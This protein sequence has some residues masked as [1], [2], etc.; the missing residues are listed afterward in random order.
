MPYPRIAWGIILSDFR[1][2]EIGAAKARAL[3]AH[4]S[5]RISL[6]HSNSGIKGRQS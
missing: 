2:S 3:R 5:A 4:T 6:N 1:K